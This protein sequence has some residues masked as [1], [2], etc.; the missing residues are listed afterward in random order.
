MPKSDGEYNRERNGV[1]IIPNICPIIVAE[2][3]FIVFEMNFDISLHNLRFG[4]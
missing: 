1:T 2:D 4:L 3:N